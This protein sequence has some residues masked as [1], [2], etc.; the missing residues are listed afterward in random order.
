LN[1]AG[2]R[3]RAG[4]FPV[5]RSR[6]KEELDFLLARVPSIY[7]WIEM[8]RR[9]INWDKR[10]Y[11]FFVGSGDV[12]LDI[13]ANVGSHTTFLSRLTRATGRVLSFEPVPQSFR[14][15]EKNIRRKGR[16]GNV[17]ASQLAIGSPREP[18]G[19]VLMQAPGTELTH[20]A[21]ARHAANAW[22]DAD[23]VQS[24]TVKISSVD[25]EAAS[26]RLFRVDFIKVDVE[27]AELEVL[28]GARRT[29]ERHQP[30]IYCEIYNE[31]ARSF[32]YSP[33]DL[34]SYLGDLGYV[35][36]RIFQE[37]RV[38]AIRIGEAVPAEFFDASADALFFGAAH[39]ERVAE[40]DRVMNARRS[41][42]QDRG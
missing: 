26:H 6:L 9:W 40:F 1:A 39:L 7:L 20:A 11:L 8:R 30:L 41:V 23:T 24:F 31:W 28:R 4:S 16:F 34:F 10:V 42:R 15:L 14:Q 35:G 36:A 37:D 18:G 25:A 22:A 33:T 12:V 21:L 27:G 17:T 32:G 2:A 5:H 3:R 38:R 13:G 19:S 29:I